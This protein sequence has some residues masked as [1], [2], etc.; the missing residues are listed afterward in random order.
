LVL[1]DT[2][3]AARGGRWHDVFGSVRIATAEM[4]MNRRFSGCL[5][6]RGADASGGRVLVEFVVAGCCVG[7]PCVCSVVVW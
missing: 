6:R 3:A 4:R 2:A 1:A 5:W 7:P